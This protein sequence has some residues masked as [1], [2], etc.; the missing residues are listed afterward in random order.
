[1]GI[2]LESD[3]SDRTKARGRCRTHYKRYLY[4][5]AYVPSPNGPQP[6]KR[7]VGE[8]W[9]DKNG[10]AKVC[11]STGVVLEHRHVMSQILGRALSSGENVQHK[12]GGS[13]MTIGQRT[14]NCG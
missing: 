8:R 12:N 4:R 9:I 14:W 13:G 1:M 2:C 6:R 5:Q 10:Y 11:L 7:T 3:C